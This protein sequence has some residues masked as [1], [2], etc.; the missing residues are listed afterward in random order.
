MCK[1]KLIKLFVVA[2][3]GNI[4]AGMLLSL[5]AGKVGAGLHWKWRRAAACAEQRFSALSV[6]V[7]VMS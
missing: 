6:V 4:C 7:W 2:V 3:T 5:G 1:L